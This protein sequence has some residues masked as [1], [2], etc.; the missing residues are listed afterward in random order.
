[1]DARGN[2]VLNMSHLLSGYQVLNTQVPSEMR[3]IL[4]LQI[5]GSEMSGLFHTTFI[6]EV[7]V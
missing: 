6:A 4:S 2:H 5:Q 3:T 1:M 7:R